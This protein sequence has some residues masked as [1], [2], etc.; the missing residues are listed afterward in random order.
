[1]MFNE[2]DEEILTALDVL[3]R[4]KERF[5]KTYNKK[6]KS[7]TFKLGDLVWKVILP[8]GKIAFWENGPQIGNDHLKFCKCIQTMH[9]KSNN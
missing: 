9:M 6:V 7:K 2:L 5:A 8:I 3:M 4:Q 1:M